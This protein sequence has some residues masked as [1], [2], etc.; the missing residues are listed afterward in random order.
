MKDV[1]SISSA[2]EILIDSLKSWTQQGVHISV[3]WTV[4]GVRGSASCKLQITF[5]P[6]PVH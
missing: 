4:Y 5:S 2:D 6:I 3:L 1:R